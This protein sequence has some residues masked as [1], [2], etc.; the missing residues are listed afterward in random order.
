M[1]LWII[2]FPLIITQSQSVWLCENLLQNV[3]N[4]ILVLLLDKY[5]NGKSGDHEIL[6][7]FTYHYE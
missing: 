1:S 3:N 7:A 6:P 4:K 2:D 5:Y